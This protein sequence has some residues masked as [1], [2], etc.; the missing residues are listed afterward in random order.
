LEPEYGQRI[1]VETEPMSTKSLGRFDASDGQGNLQIV[2]VEERVHST[3][4]DGTMAV[5]YSF[6][7]EKV[8]KLRPPRVL[9]AINLALAALLI[10]FTVQG[11]LQP[12]EQPNGLTRLPIFLAGFVVFM[13]LS[14]IESR[15]MRRIVFANTNYLA[16]KS[17]EDSYGSKPLI[18][19][20]QG[21]VARAQNGISVVL[22][23]LPQS[24]SSLIN[25][26]LDGLDG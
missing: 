25:P 15:K 16:L 6:S 9:A 10:V 14:T 1:E 11:L 22:H 12:S 26:P 2:T 18:D 8:E 7:K 13:V 20:P 3:N 21:T 23:Q 17:I 4:I 19:L 5:S 24:R